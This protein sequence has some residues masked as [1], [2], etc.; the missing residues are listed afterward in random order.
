ME[1]KK[2]DDMHCDFSA[3]DGLER[4]FNFVLAG[5]HDGKTTTFLMRKAWPAFLKEGMATVLLFRQI[6]TVNEYTIR[7][8]ETLMNPFLDEPLNLKCYGEKS[9][10]MTAMKD[11]KPFLYAVPLA[12]KEQQLKQTCFPNVKY[13]VFDELEIN[14]Q[15]NERYLPS[16]Y[17]SFETLFGT[18]SKVNDRL[19][20]YALSNPYS[21][22]NPY[23]MAWGVNTR[24]LRIGTMQKGKNW[25]VWF[26][27]LNPKLI[28][29]LKEKDPLFDEKSEYGRWAYGGCFANDRNNH[30]APMRGGYRLIQRFIF[31]G[32]RFGAYELSEWD[33][34]SLPTYYLKKDKD[35]GERRTAMAFDFSDMVANTILFTK[36]DRDSLTRLKRAMKCQDYACDTIET[37][38]AFQL[39]Y[40]VI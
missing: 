9:G 13:I 32:Q 29:W 35:R 12:M 28:A 18:M 19:R 22:Y 17:Q 20:F 8:Y 7:Y 21:A 25:A 40:E 14:P 2:L 10:V 27:E 26:K 30:V 36:Q 4:T 11:K 6:N 1:K 5:R 39:I 23:F 3:I 34:D 16:E 24:A 31:E 37:E 15:K 33:N 38:N